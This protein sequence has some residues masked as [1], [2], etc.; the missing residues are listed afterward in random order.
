MRAIMLL[1]IAALLAACSNK[2]DPCVTSNDC[3]FG[4]VCGPDG[5]CAA[6]QD[7]WVNDTPN[8]TSMD[9]SGGVDSTTDSAGV[10]DMDRPQDDAGP[11]PD[12]DVVDPDMTMDPD[13]A[14]PDMSMPDDMCV[15]DPF[16]VCEDDE[17]PDNNA[18]PGVALT[19]MTRGCQPSGFVPL[20]M[21]ISGRQCALDPED[22]YYITVVEC[23]A[24]EP[25]MIIE[26]T[27]SVAQDCNP[28]LIW[29]DV[30]SIGTSCAD[31]DPDSDLTL[32]CE[33]LTNGDRR[34]SVI[35][36]GSSVP[37]VG[38]IRYSIQTPDRTDLQFDYDLRVV[39]REP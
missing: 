6:P 26:A 8:N 22:Q 37:V 24:D 35:W 32:R 16:D 28:D 10:G 31:P 17:D 23:D 4:E 15:V 1:A 11:A 38:S 29:F 9:A 5:F 14:R 3:F 2:G 12:M 25:G 34:I 36:P 18:F 39:I 21:T 33:T 27:L 30:E 19:P 20:D 13:F 7:D